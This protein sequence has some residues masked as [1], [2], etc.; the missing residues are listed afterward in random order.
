[1]SFNYLLVWIVGIACVSCVLQSVTQPIHQN[2]GWLIVS[3]LVLGTTIALYSWVPTKAGW[4]GSGLWLVLMVVPSIGMRRVNRLFAQESY[5]QASQL[6]ATL[7]WLHPFDGWLEHPRIFRALDLGQQGALE[8]ARTLLSF[9]QSL[10]TPVSRMAQALLFRMEAQ[11]PELLTWLEKSVPESVLKQDASLQV[12]YLRSLGET[13]DLNGLVQRFSEFERRLARSRSSSNLML[14]RLFALAFCGQTQPVRYLFSGPLASYSANTRRFWLATAEIAAGNELGAGRY[15]ELCDRQDPT[16]N[17][18]IT[19]RLSHPSPNPKEILTDASWQVLEQINLEL[20]QEDRYSGRAFVGQRAY[21]TYGLIGLNLLVFALELWLGGSQNFKTL[22]RLGAMV[23]Q[24]VM[25][26]EWWRLLAA[27][28]LHFGVLHLSMNMLGLLVLGPFV[29]FMLGRW[30]YLCTYLMSG[31]GSMLV[32][33]LL[34]VTMKDSTDFVV[35]AS[36]AIMGLLGGIG[37][38]YLQGW[39]KDRARVAAQRLRMIGL[40]VILQVFFDLLTPQVSFIG[41]ASGLVLGFIA[42]AILLLIP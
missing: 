14:S 36:G 34:A 37:A 41:H 13:G 9:H 16:V 19:W 23:P 20:Q 2:R 5:Q 6:A 22:Y 31:V 40:A 12:Y 38:I 39:F 10:S 27:T 30:K 26:G 11:W 35:G 33:T 42:V 25:A 3:T 21:V 15:L 28:F 32:L 29:E 18:A 8:D 1:M 4:V 17:R 7:R 24:A